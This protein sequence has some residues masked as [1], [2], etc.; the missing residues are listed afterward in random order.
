ML[1]HKD[2]IYESLLG[3]SVYEMDILADNI[4]SN[5]CIRRPI[6]EKIIFSYLEE[7]MQTVEKINGING[8]EKE[9]LSIK[10]LYIVIDRSKLS[11]VNKEKLVK[12]VESMFPSVINLVIK[13]TNGY[14]DINK[15]EEKKRCIIL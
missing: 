13:G 6:D 7:I 3:K 15:E 1:F 4:A 10:V 9:I 5:L 12:I 11:P 2:N 14:L 8:G